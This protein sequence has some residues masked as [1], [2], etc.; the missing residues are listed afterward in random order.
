VIVFSC[1]RVA[2]EPG[3][4]VCRFR[5]AAIGR[6]PAFARCVSEELSLL[7]AAEP[8]WRSRPQSRHELD[9]V[10]HRRLF[11]PSRPPLSWLTAC[12]AGSC[13]IGGKKWPQMWLSLGAEAHIPCAERQDL[14]DRVASERLVERQPR[15]LVRARP[16]SRMA[17]TLV[18]IGSRGRARR[19]HREASDGQG[20]RIRGRPKPQIGRAAGVVASLLLRYALRRNGGDRDW[21]EAD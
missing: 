19:R 17:G 20:G 16:T 10:D 12:R 13:R 21:N 2:Y 5:P 6:R 3:G 15:G 4:C 9:T 14:G 7:F 8:Q 18:W 11:P 1:R